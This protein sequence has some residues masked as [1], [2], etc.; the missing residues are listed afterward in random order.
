[1]TDPLATLHRMVQRFNLDLAGVEPPDRPT[2]LGDDRARF[3][4]GHLVEEL[5]E[6][7]TGMARKDLGATVDGLLDLTYVALGALVEM[8][9]TAGAAF[10]EVHAAN[11]RKAVGRNPKRPD[12]T[13]TKPEGWEPPDLTPYLTLTREEVLYMADQVTM[14]EE[15]IGCEDDDDEPR[16]EATNPRPRILVIGH[17]RH[18]K[19]TVCEHLRDRYGMRFTSSSAFCA[20]RVIWPILKNVENAGAFFRSLSED[21]VQQLGAEIYEM[22]AKYQ[23]VEQCFHGRGDHREFWYKAIRAFNRPDPTALARAIMEE[24]DVYCGMRSSAELHAC[25][26]ADVFDHVVWVDASQRVGPEDESSC[27]VHPWM[28]DWVV[29]AN[30]DVEASRRNVDRLME[31]ILR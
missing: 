31:R 13:V 4:L 2:L 15:Y 10:E 18:G 14:A 28:A 22:R 8:G 20:G 5:K 1:M 27:T 7:E 17:A 16:D 19:D 23:T 25:H 3:R 6:I 12:D 24:N 11:M 30:E 26:A 29:D 21:R 9:I